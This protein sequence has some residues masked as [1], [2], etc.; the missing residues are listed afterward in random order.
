MKYSFLL[1]STVLLVFS[2]G[3]NSNQKVIFVKDM[4]ELNEAIAKAT[5]GDEIVMANGTWKDVH[6]NFSGKGTADKPIV[7]RAETAGKVN[8][9]GISFLKIG[10][11]YLEVDG[12]YFKNGYSDSGAVIEF[13]IDNENIANH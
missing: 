12:L 11:K 3:E 2:C 1:I 4:V 6:I 9:E 5:P 8:I 7:L 13:R 10:G